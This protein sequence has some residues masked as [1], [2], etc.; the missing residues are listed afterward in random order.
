MS[1]AVVTNIVGEKDDS[2]IVHFCNKRGEYSEIRNKGLCSDFARLRVPRGGFG[3]NALYLI[4]LAFNELALMRQVL[5]VRF[6]CTPT[7]RKRVLAIAGRFTRHASKVTLSLCHEQSEL[8]TEVLSGIDQL[9][10][11]I[12]HWLPE[13]LANA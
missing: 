5:P 6:E 12:E 1:R 2:E 9:L 11:N 13:S 10:N 8:L 3:A 4:A 7:V